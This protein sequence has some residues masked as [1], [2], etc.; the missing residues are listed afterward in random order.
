MICKLEPSAFTTAILVALPISWY[1]SRCELGD[2]DGNTAAWLPERV[3]VFVP[4]AFM[5]SS[6]LL[7]PLLNA[8]LL[9]SGDH[10]GEYSYWSGVLVML[11]R[12]VPSGLIIYKSQFSPGT[13][14]L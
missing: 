5:A 6:A 12:S 4:S 13:P 3:R 10:M 14:W 1:T 11:V 7:K 9:P 8:S 2:H